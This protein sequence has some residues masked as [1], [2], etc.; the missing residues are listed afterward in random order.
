MV[1]YYIAET[2][3]FQGK[4]DE[5]LRYGESVLARGGTLYYEKEMKLLIGQLHFEKKNFAKALPLLE[6][7]VSKTEK[8]D[9]E[10]LY[11]LSYC[12]YQAN[13][14]QK[15]I[16]GF[17]QLSNQK[18][19]MGQNS[20][21][22]LGDCYLRTNQ[23][24]N[25][26]NAFQYCAYNNSNLKQQEVS[27]FIYAKLSYELGYQDIALNELTEKRDL[28]GIQM[29]KSGIS[30]SPEKTYVQT[31]QTV[32][33]IVR[34][35]LSYKVQLGAMIQVTSNSPEIIVVNPEVM[36]KPNKS[37]PTVGEARIRI[38]GRQVGGEGTV[39]AA[40]GKMRAHAEVQVHS[41]KEDLV[42]P[43]SKGSNALFNDIRF[44]DRTD[45]RQRVYFDR[46]NSSIVIATA[47]PS[48]KIYLDANERLDTSVQ[49][50]VLLAELVAEAVCREIARSGVER[51]KF[52]VLDGSEA[53]A[54][55]NHFIRLQNR[56]AHL[57]H[58]YIVSRE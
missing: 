11:E 2:Y 16:D 5:A 13:Q 44:D 34:V 15:A 24:A 53:D 52:L 48:V 22:L 8:V 41:K 36:L 26:R 56:Y 55:Q 28:K 3:Y 35:K 12:Y 20:M 49:G 9:K 27:R 33:L 38:E 43:P 14:L 58:E 46:V 17:K 4:K 23:K 50:Q 47:A 42:A 54:I 37:D 19:S 51:G 45:P 57:I 40:I 1:P 29:P 31:G 6:Y 18:D 25:A 21:Y 39:T 10:V 30:L 7:Y 32:Q